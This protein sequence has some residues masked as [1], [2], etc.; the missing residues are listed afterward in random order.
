M[1]WQRL[2]YYIQKLDSC[3]LLRS[4]SAT[5][6]KAGNVYKIILTIITVP[7]LYYIILGNYIIA[8]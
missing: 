7:I 8:I 1:I 6:Y 3:L 4:K 5:I 2:I